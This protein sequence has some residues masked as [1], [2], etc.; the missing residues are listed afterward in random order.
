MTRWRD[1]LCGKVV[2]TSPAHEAMASPATVVQGTTPLL[3]CGGSFLPHPARHRLR[4]DDV[5]LPMIHLPKD[6]Y[7]IVIS[8]NSEE[9]EYYNDD[10]RDIQ[11]ELERIEETLHETHH[12]LHN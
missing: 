2:P 4:G 10:N 6:R 5:S 1:T 8:R 3:S 12:K 7:E 9:L 11:D